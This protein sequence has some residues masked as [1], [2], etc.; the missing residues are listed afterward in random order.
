M[1]KDLTTYFGVSQ[2]PHYATWTPYTPAGRRTYSSESSVTSDWFLL[3]EITFLKT[4]VSMFPIYF[5][6][7]ILPHYCAGDKIEKNAMGGAY[8]AYGGGERRVQGFC[9]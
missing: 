8:S 9:G 3:Q 2:Q 4:H 5:V 6:S 7:Y 1:W